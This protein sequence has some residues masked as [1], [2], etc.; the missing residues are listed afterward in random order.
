MKKIVLLSFLALSALLWL[1]QGQELSVRYRMNYNTQSPSLFEEAGLPPEMRQMLAEAYKDVWLYFMLSYK[2]GK[3]S[4][5]LVRDSVKRSIQFMG[6]TIDLTGHMDEMAKAYRYKDHNG[7]E[8]LE[9]TPVMG[10]VYLLTATLDEAPYIVDKSQKREILGYECFRATS[11]DGKTKV[12]YTP[13][14][15]LKDEPIPTGL[16]GLVL[17]LEDGQQ[18]LRAIEIL[19]EASEEPKAPQE[20]E[21]MPKKEFEEMMK[22]QVERMQRNH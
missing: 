21:R 14:I 1:L 6:Q 5:R 13:H 12:W 4:F 17:E 22:K 10:K 7:R 11:P 19:P 16:E 9:V 20:G 3:S 2:E 15:P 18:L 8:L